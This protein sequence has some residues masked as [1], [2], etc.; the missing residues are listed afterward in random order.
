MRIPAAY[1]GVVG[2]KPSYGRLSRHGLVAYASSLDTPGIISRNVATAVDF[3][4]TAPS[5]PRAL[6]E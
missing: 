5:L 3:I 6:V 2:F 1:C 4:G